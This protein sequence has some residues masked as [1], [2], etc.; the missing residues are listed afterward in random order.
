M[1]ALKRLTD[2]GADAQ[3]H[4]SV[5][6]PIPRGAGAVLLACKDDERNVLA[7]VSHG[8]II[9][10]QLIAGWIVDRDAALDARNHLI[11]DTDVRKGAPDHHFM[12]PAP[13]SVLIE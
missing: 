1:N 10:R 2:H 11:S 4:R 12:V 6:G 5:G 3:Q 8:R 9:D 13:G 7:L